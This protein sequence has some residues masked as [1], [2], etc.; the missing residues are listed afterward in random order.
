MPEAHDVQEQL[1]IAENANG[2]SY[3]V[4]LHPAGKAGDLRAPVVRLFMG[5]LVK[6]FTGYIRRG[7]VPVLFMQDEFPALVRMKVVEEGIAYLAEY[8]VNFCLFAQDLKQLAATYG[9][10]T[11]SILTNS[12]VKQFFGVA[13]YETAQLVSHMCGET[14]IPPAHQLFKRK[15]HD[16]EGAECYS[17]YSWA[18][19]L[20]TQ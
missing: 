14:T 8:G 6:H 1:P 17:K 19:T 13:D 15:R 16:A 9:D 4:F 7:Q 3:G 20:H 2:A 10:K 18:T 5:M 11:D 12:A